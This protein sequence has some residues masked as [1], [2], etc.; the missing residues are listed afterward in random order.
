MVMVVSGGLLDVLDDLSARADH[1]TDH[2]L[3]DGDLYDA[4]YAG[5]VVGA[6]LGDALGE[7][8]EDVHAAL[9]G[10]LQRGGQHLVGESVHLDVHLRGGDAVLGA[11]HLEV[12]VAQVVFIAQNVRQHGPLAGLGVGDQTHGDARHGFLDLHAGVHQRQGSGADRRHR[13]RAVRLK[14]VRHDAHGVGVLVAQRD[15]RLQGAPCQV[16]VADLA[17]ATDRVRPW[18]RPSRKAGSYSGARTARCPARAL[19][20]L[21]FSSSFV[22]SVTV[23]SDWVSPRVKIAEPWAAGR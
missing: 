16:A 2:I 4:R 8:A 14:D 9:A 21:T 12:H 23:V 15:H 13:R 20:P 1:R 6:R 19:R 18:P 22:P 17:A 7:F 5:L 3:R 10:L 11:R